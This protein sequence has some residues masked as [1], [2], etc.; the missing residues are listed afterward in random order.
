MRER[1]VVG[2]SNKILKDFLFCVCV[3]VCVCTHICV[4][5]YHGEFVKNRE[6][7]EELVVF[8]SIDPA[9]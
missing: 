3:C 8:S 4:Q 2:M 6:Q 5:A 7:L 1:T 9:D